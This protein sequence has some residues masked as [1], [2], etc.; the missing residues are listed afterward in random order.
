MT[1]T[2]TEVT[3]CSGLNHYHFTVDI[4]GQTHELVFNRSDFDLEPK[5]LE[6]AFLN[7]VRSAVKEAGA[8]TFAQARVAVLNKEF[9]L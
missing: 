7:R 4:A 3:R 6:Q 9:K 1:L 5:E 8:T 2:I